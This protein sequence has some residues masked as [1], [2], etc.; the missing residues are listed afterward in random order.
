MTALRGL[1]L[2]LWVAAIE[3]I[4]A[5]IIAGYC[6][7]AVWALMR[8][9]DIRAARLRIAQGAITG[10]SYKLAATLLKTILLLSWRQIAMFAAIFALR[11]LLKRLFLWE[12]QRL[13]DQGAGLS[14]SG[15]RL[16]PP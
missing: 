13:T 1:H 5:L 2:D 11:T 8:S 9:R 15:Q 14:S 6:A 16:Q 3:M 12:Q 4:G 7:A 10:L